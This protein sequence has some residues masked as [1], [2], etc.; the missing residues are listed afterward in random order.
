MHYIGLPLGAF[1]I[2][3]PSGEPSEKYSEQLPAFI[4]SSNVPYPTELEQ[5]Q[6]RSDD[7]LAE[8]YGNIVLD[9]AGW[10]VA[11]ALRQNATSSGPE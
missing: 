2:T 5:S 8:N 1:C 10:A 4:H 7:Y 6:Q 11:A 9:Q 3:E